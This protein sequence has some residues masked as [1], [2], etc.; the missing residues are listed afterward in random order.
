MGN[1]TANVSTG[2][3]QIAGALF[4]AAIGSKLPATASEALDAAFKALGYVSEDGFK[5]SN[6]PESETVKAWGGDVVLNTQTGRPDKFS[7]KLIESL[8]VDVL[9]TVYGEKNVTGTLDQ[10]IA[11][12]VNNKNAEEYAWV[13]DM[14]LKGGVLKRIVIPQA[15][16]T[17]VG[18]IVYKDNEVIGYDTTITA[19]RDAEGQYHYEYIQK[20]TVG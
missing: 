15:A 12:K 16:I 1:S 3:P 5:N 9:K 17:A 19:T 4:R 10:G 7:F 11:V 18:D 6:S 8:N 14:I 13:C 20:K 2:K